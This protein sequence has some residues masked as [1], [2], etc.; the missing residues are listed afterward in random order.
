[1]DDKAINKVM[2]R[3]IPN[4]FLTSGILPIIDKN[5]DTAL[6]IQYIIDSFRYAVDKTFDAEDIK[7]IDKIIELLENTNGL[8]IIEDIEELENRPKSRQIN[9]K[10]RQSLND[11]ENYIKSIKII[12]EKSN[13]SGFANPIY[14]IGN[15]F[16]AK[17]TY[18][19]EESP[20]FL[21]CYPF[22]KK[23]YETGGKFTTIK[24][25]EHNKTQKIY[26]NSPKESYEC[27]INELM[28][29]K[30]DYTLKLMP[31][32]FSPNRIEP[33]KILNSRKERNFDLRRFICFLT[34]YLLEDEDCRRFVEKNK[35]NYIIFIIL[36]LSPFADY[37]ANNMKYSKEV[38]EL[39]I[40]KVEI[41]NDELIREYFNINYDGQ[42]IECNKSDK[43]SK[44]LSAF[45]ISYFEASEKLK[46][47]YEEFKKDYEECREYYKREIERFDMP[48]GIVQKLVNAANGKHYTD[49]IQGTWGEFPAEESDNISNFLEN[50]LKKNNE[51][52]YFWHIEEKTEYHISVPKIQVM[53]KPFKYAES[54]IREI[55]EIIHIKLAF[56]DNE[57]SSI[58]LHIIE[59]YLPPNRYGKIF[60][61]RKIPKK[62]IPCDAD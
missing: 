48:D 26:F 16:I 20:Y 33:K 35:I 7:S 58:Y 24:P 45:F 50:I 19:I 62:L 28:Q 57:K 2:L 27:M 21:K 12:K 49:G 22:L 11:K 52:K 1:M 40:K 4:L 55:E 5:P 46:K 47:D 25:A 38:L 13:L 42:S 15:R 32:N 61:F 8:N 59:Y 9:R 39:C 37:V 6:Y 51:N 3:L 41:A 44:E 23:I 60:Q 54:E 43:P 10:L 29:I 34:F 30:V 56:K 31:F 14:E 53:W 18:Y 17:D 36:M